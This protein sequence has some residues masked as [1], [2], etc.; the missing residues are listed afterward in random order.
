MLS[1]NQ[2]IDDFF[3]K[4][5]EAF[6]P[7]NQLAATHWQQ[8]K[9]QL[10]EPGGDPDKRSP[11]NKHITR[12]LGLLVVA[13]VV[14]ITA[15]NPFKHSKKKI[16]ATTKQQT[17]VVPRAIP[18]QPDTITEFSITPVHP[19]EKKGT[20]IIS[21]TN[22][23]ACMPFIPPP[24]EEPS[25]EERLQ[26]FYQQLGKASQEFYI[27]NTRDTSLVAKEG[28]RLFVPTNTLI[29]KAG[30][31]K[32]VVREYYKYEDIVAAKLTTTSNGQQ[33]ITGGMLH[34]SA[35]QDG[36]PVT[37][38]PQKAITVNVPTDNYDDRMQL[39][40]GQQSNTTLNWLQV[41]PFHQKMIDH[42]GHIDFELN[43]NKVQPFSVSYGKKTTAKFYVART[44]NVSK[45]ELTTRLKQRFG[46][47]YDVIKIKRAPKKAYMEEQL[48]IDSTPVYDT[49]K[50]IP[51]YNTN[52]SI[53]ISKDDGGQQDSFYL[54]Q[55]GRLR[56]TYDFALTSF[57]WYNCD[58]F[59]NDPRPKVNFNVYLDKGATE[60]NHVCLLV[61]T[62]NKSI[63]R[64]V[65]RGGQKVYFPQI[66]VG[67]SAILV[68][69]AVT[70]DNVVSNMHPV[71]ISETAVRN[72]TFTPTTPEQF[73]Q[74]LQSLF[75]SQ[76]Q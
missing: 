20:S 27:D 35:E 40:T 37:I 14:I 69:V 39:F 63:V 12:L 30:P 6:A 17:T 47:Y 11:G 67:E 70:A 72:L 29:K 51:A 59:S 10:N 32:I 3:R 76:K 71:T 60:G 21:V 36:V 54:V 64:S 53:R 61:F 9:T 1:D 66:P 8:F 22:E 33:L 31:V 7:D 18:A 19:V 42:S 34:I 74:Q 41:G 62:R 57:G 56:N 5:E 55:Q 52:A 2:H 75:A 65:Y 28:T 23:I 68:T 16:P 24:I 44:I 38:A 50:F 46:N 48:V 13:A 58:K 26:Q 49:V 25:A 73:K 15:I 45:A 4:K 43:V